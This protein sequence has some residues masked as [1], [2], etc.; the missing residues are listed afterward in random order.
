[1][2]HGSTGYVRLDTRSCKACWECI[3]ACPQGVIGKIE[4]LFHRHVRIIHAERCK[5]CLVC[6]KTCPHSA[7]VAVQTNLPS[8]KEAFR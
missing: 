2:R 4:I 6:V 8:E 5:G 3:E 7:I 1:M